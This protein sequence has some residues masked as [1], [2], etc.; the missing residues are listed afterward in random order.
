MVIQLGVPETHNIKPRIT[1]FGVGGAGGN[2]VDN[3]IVK[4]LAGV[5]FIV[6]NTDAQALEEARADRRIQFGPSVTQGLGA[7][8]RPDIGKA[9]AEEALDQIAEQLGTSHMVFITAGMGGGTGTGAAPVVARTAREMGMLTVGFVTMPFDF[10]GRERMRIAE[11]GI[12]ELQEEVDTLIVIPNQNLF[13]LANDKTTFA[14]AFRIADEVL[15]TGVRGI[16]DLMVQPG[17]IN[18]DF[19]DVRRVMGERGKAMMGTGEASGENRALAAA[20]A[21][22]AN[23]LLDEVSMSGA[24]GV[25]INV[26]GGGDMTLYE[27]DEATRRINQET[28]PEAHVIIGAACDESMEGSMRVSLVATGINHSE[29]AVPRPEAERVRPPEEPLEAPQDGTEGRDRFTAIDGGKAAVVAEPDVW[30]EENE[31][32]AVAGGEPA[33][34]REAGR[35]AIDAFIAPRPVDPR[36]M[37]AAA[38]RDPGE[39]GTRVD[40]RGMSAADGH[41]EIQAQRRPS[42]FER[43]T[44][45]MRPSRERPAPR[46]PVIERPAVEPASEHYA[47]RSDPRDGLFRDDAVKDDPLEIPPFLRRK[48]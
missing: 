9:A 32:R 15:Y 1:V 38:S 13:R 28:D 31:V 6:A 26:T 35:A 19:A 2:A 29:V 27:V 39:D 43:V 22:I 23:P 16:T 10:E 44:G 3:M 48:E 45:G 4:G 21:A 42:L 46:D 18:L 24:C 20:E 17:I 5:E 14:D 33:G 47:R 41:Q 34:H 11:R 37:P 7:G 12:Q 36:D 25:L 30:Q 40:P 8:S